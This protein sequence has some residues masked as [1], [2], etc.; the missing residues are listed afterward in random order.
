MTLDFSFL[1]AAS[2]LKPRLENGYSLQFVQVGAG[3]TGS[4]L[5]PHLCRI[6]K[7]L[8]QHS[9][10]LSVKII[11]PDYVEPPNLVRQNFCPAELGCN[12]AETL[13][14][15]YGAA[16]GLEVVA[17][18]QPFDPALLRTSSYSYH[19]TTIILIGCVDNY[20]ARRQLAE[21]L[22][23]NQA[24]RPA[25]IW[26]LDLGNFHSG[27][28]V[29]L[30]NTEN[31]DRLKSAFPFEELCTALPSPALQHPELL[32]PEPQAFSPSALS[33]A[34]L[35]CEEL[36]LHTTQSLTINQSMAAVASTYLVRLLSGRLKYFQ[37][38]LNLEAMTTKSTYVTPHHVA[39]VLN[40][41]PAHEATFFVKS[42]NAYQPPSSH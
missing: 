27:G 13:A 19:Q 21:C 30:G 11:D 37:T 5:A 17:I 42:A 32:E 4:W 7:I 20:L 8:Q 10:N 25:P 12:K 35:S 9:L 29:L 15:R 16:L 41:S 31:L 1:K 2:I 39:K 38:Y 26:W 36:S 24:Y 40:L 18:A 3:G 6:A 34:N 23:S 28:Q 33:E 14:L 22:R